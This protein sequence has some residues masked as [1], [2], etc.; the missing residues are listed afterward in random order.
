MGYTNDSNNSIENRGNLSNGIN[1]INN[2]MQVKSEMFNSKR[3]DNTFIDDYF[4]P[5]NLSDVN[6]QFN[7]SFI[8][9]NEAI[10]KELFSQFSDK[11]PLRRWASRFISEDTTYYG[12]SQNLNVD[13]V[14][15][16]FIGART[17]RWQFAWEIYTKEYNWKQKIF[18][19]GF[20]F[21]NWYGLYFLGDKKASDY[22][23]NPF[24][25]ILLYSGIVGLILYILLLFKGFYYYIKYI[26]VSYLFFIFFLITFFFSFF[27]AGSPFD[28]PIMGFF[29][30]LPFFVHSIH[31][32][33]DE[34]K[35]KKHDR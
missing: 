5:F 23:H 6:K 14:S 15:N 4:L 21:L 30:M 1:H 17:M 32:R 20:N 26:K 28:P 7:A 16:N 9:V 13:T 22:P 35:I 10:I 11:D 2:R 34:Q 12:Y 18:G 25:Y 3:T 27:S 33:D 8:N 29:I 24:L 31:K 19:G